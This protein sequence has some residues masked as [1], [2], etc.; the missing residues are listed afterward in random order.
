MHRDGFRP[1]IP[2]H[3]DDQVRAMIVA[4]W[5]TNPDDRPSFE[6][7][8]EVLDLAD[9]AFYSDVDSDSVRRFIDEVNL[10]SPVK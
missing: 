8:F 9:F 10:I 1:S 5:A 6:D 4:C 7:I 2:D 3:V